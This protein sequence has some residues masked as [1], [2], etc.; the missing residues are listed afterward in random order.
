MTDKLQLNKAVRA[1]ADYRSLMI[2][3]YI[4]S[5]ALLISFLYL[6]Y[7]RYAVSP[8]YILIFLYALPPILT[9]AFT[10]YGKRYH[11]KLLNS[12]TQDNPNLLTTLRNKYH[13][14][15]L[16]YIA[17]SIS[18]LFMMI[19]LLLWQY[20]NNRTT[21]IKSELI[22]IPTIILTGSILLRIIGS[23]YYRIK[24]PYDLIHNRV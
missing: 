8:L 16:N 18:Y 2:S 1:I 15:R 19:L 12:F 10:D 21:F 4:T 6:G 9:F 17:N 23:A 20:S 3:K 5:A 7:L 11:F 22:N 14:T 24:L 13:Y